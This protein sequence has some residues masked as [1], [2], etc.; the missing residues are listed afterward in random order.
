[1]KL[2]LPCI[3]MGTESC[4]EQNSL[5]YNLIFEQPAIRRSFED[6]EERWVDG[7]KEDLQKM[8][9]MGELATASRK[10]GLE[11]SLDDVI[12]QSTGL[13]HLRHKSYGK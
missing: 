1:M 6:P 10:R 13:D 12:T 3:Y 9:S 2:A 7:V 5:N 11:E 4:T 8:Q